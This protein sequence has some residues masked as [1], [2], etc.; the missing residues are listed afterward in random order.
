MFPVDEMGPHE[1]QGTTLELCRFLYQTI[2]NRGKEMPRERDP[3]GVGTH[4]P[5]KKARKKKQPTGRVTLARLIGRLYKCL[6]GN[7]YNL[8]KKKSA[9]R[10]C[11]AQ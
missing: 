2:T 10:V 11:Q 5:Q 8:R 1:E 4:P 9:S 7:L 6:R 3:H